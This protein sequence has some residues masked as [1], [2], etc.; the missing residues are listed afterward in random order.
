MAPQSHSSILVRS[1]A[2]ARQAREG[3]ARGLA[4]TRRPLLIGVSLTA[5]LLAALPAAFH[6]L[7]FERW[8][9]EDTSILLLGIGLTVGGALLR[10][11][12][13]PAPQAADAESP[14]GVRLTSA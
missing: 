10:R 9:T 4:Q 5:L 7:P 1:Y 11:R 3:N 2:P 13:R 12:T 6:R 14:G 8:F